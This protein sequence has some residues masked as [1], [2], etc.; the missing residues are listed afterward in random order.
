MTPPPVTSMVCAI[1]GIYARPR[2]ARW[3]PL[4]APAPAPRA[5]GQRGTFPTSFQYTGKRSIFPRCNCI[6]GGSYDPTIGCSAGW[7]L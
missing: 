3:L 6:A 1:V 4:T 5:R 2:H 7:R